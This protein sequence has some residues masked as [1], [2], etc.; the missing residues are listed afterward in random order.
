MYLYRDGLPVH[1]FHIALGAHPV[2]DKVHAGDE[3]TPEGAYI[4]DWRNP[5]SVYY[6]SIHIS[7]P[8]ATDR[9]TAARRGVDPGGMIMIH[10]QPDY[11]FT[12][13]TGDWTNGCIAVSNSA[14]DIIWRTVPD[15]TPIHIY[16]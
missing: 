3:R 12:K 11:A 5:G 6:K 14:M 8:D 4:L 15:D 1:K 7:Y 9:R 13:R 2:G 16:P 10:G